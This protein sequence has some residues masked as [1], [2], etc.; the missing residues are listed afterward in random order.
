MDPKFWYHNCYCYLTFLY[1]YDYFY[2]VLST[3]ITCKRLICHLSPQWS[4]FILLLD[5]CTLLHL[6]IVLFRFF[7]NWQ[8]PYLEMEDVKFFDQAIIA[9]QVNP[10]RFNRFPSFP[11]AAPIPAICCYGPPRPGTRVAAVNVLQL[12]GR[13]PKKQPSA[14]QIY[15]QLLLATIYHS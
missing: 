6:T 1:F 10:R 8:Y 14:T 12:P 13:M 11:F 2:R 15:H 9:M 7:T 4:V 5:S 3:I